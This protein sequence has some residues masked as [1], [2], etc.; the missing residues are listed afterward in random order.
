[1]LIEPRSGEA[2]VESASQPGVLYRVSRDACTCLA[3]QHGVPCKHRAAL[4]AQFG[5]L[6]LP[7]REPASVECPTCFGKGW[8][9]AGDDYHWPDQV[10]CRKCAGTGHLAVAIVRHARPVALAAA[11]D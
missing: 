2:F 6:P 1:M 5:E 11:A 9:Y 4:L 8:G 10:A 7:E 3:G